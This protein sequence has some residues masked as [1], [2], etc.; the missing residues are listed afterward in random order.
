M[1][2][3]CQGVQWWVVCA[4]TVVALLLGTGCGEADEAPGRAPMA[5]VLRFSA[6]AALGM[7]GDIVLFGSDMACG[8][9]SYETR[10][11]C[12]TPAGEGVRD[13][14]YPDVYDIGSAAPAYLGRVD[15]RDRVVGCDVLGET[16]V[17]LVD[18]PVTPADPAG[19]PQRGIDWY[20][21]AS[22]PVPRN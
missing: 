18:R 15:V 19:I 22:A 6:N 16:L 2:S 8:I 13:S 7:A 17:V 21:L 5:P 3:T 12:V 4:G 14:S 1:I 9:E 11:Y 10:I 20:Q